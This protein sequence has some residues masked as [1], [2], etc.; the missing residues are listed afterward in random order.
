MTDS[1]RL[2]DDVS[3]ECGEPRYD[4]R[5]LCKDLYPVRSLSFRREGYE[6]RKC[7]QH[8]L[9]EARDSGEDAQF[10]AQPDY[11]LNGRPRQHARRLY[12]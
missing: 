2:G 3:L 5:S 1:A 4:E 9:E 8:L 12:G 11:R 10:A 6:V 7:V